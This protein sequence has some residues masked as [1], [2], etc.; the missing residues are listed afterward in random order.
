MQ[1]QVERGVNKTADSIQ[2]GLTNY[3]CDL[4]YDR[5]SPE[6]IHAAK[7]RLIDNLGA[8]LCGFYGEP[9]VISRRLAAHRRSSVARPSI[10][11]R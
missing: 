10:T 7:V 4:N 6:A 1:K 2:Q 8:L 3:A 11:C 9:C 5:L